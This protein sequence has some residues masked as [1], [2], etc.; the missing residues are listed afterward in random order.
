MVYIKE[1]EILQT[2]SKNNYVYAWAHTR[3]CTRAH[4]HMYNL[5]QFLQETYEVGNKV[6]IISDEKAKAFRGYMKPRFKPRCA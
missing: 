6:S 2:T 4:T 3:V 1:K 5:I